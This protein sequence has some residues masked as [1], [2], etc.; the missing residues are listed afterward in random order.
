MRSKSLTVRIPWPLY[1]A[2]ERLCQEHHCENMHACIIGA[3]TFAVQVSRI[4]PRVV[5]VANAKPKLQDF[6]L[7]K[8]LAFPTDLQGMVK[9][10]KKL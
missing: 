7:D 10:L 3:C 8:W 6:V 1:S 5:E 9:E 4:A 2:L